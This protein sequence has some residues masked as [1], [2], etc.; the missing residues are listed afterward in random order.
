MSVLDKYKDI[1]NIDIDVFDLDELKD[2]VKEQIVDSKIDPKTKKGIGY[3]KDENIVY[4]VGS[5]Y[6]EYRAIDDEIEVLIVIEVRQLYKIE[7][8]LKNGKGRYVFEETEEWTIERE[9]GDIYK[10]IDTGNTTKEYVNDVLVKE[11]IEYKSR[12][13][14]KYYKDGE[15]EKGVVVDNEKTLTSHVDYENN[16]PT[17]AVTFSRYGRKEFDEYY[18]Y[19]EEDE[20]GNKLLTKYEKIKDGE[21]IELIETEYYENGDEK[22]EHVIRPDIEYWLEYDEDYIEI[23]RKERKTNLEDFKYFRDLLPRESAPAKV[24]VDNR[25]RW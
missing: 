11:T 19:N 3:D 6:E 5:D 21:L 15:V 25:G 7:A 20:D 2:Y 22:K 4:N 8:K 14:T 12:T 17:H 10:K 23:Y 1:E 13:E 16:N 9:N 18:E 24:I